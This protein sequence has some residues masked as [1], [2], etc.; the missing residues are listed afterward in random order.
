MQDFQDYYQGSYQDSSKISKLS[1]P[2]WTFI[3]GNQY[4]ETKKRQNLVK[5]RT[6]E[7]SKKDNFLQNMSKTASRV[8]RITFFWWSYTILKES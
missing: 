1:S 6:I 3:I 7:E 8:D 2:A 5:M 4:N